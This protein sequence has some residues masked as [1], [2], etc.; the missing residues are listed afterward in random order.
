M[1]IAVL[2]LWHLGSVTA[3]CLAAAGHQVAGFDPAPAVV[4]GLQGGRPPIA[5]PGLSELVATGVADGT[6]RFTDDLASAVSHA[7]LVWVTFD[8]PVDEEDVADVRYVLDQVEAAF[9]HLATDAVVLCSSQLPVGSVKRL[10]EQWRTVA[11]ARRVSFASSPE[12]LR[13]GKAIDVFTH[14]D[15]VVVGVRDDRA[16]AVIARALAPIT[17]RIEWM[18]VESAEMTKHAVNAFL[19]TSVTFINELAS[20]CERVG[21]DAGDVERGLRTERRI[22]PQAYL[23]PGAAFAGGTLAR[24]VTFLRALGTAVG[25]PT[26]LMDGVLQSNTA[27]VS[28]A[29]RRLE[30][31]LGNLAGQRIAVW[32]LTYKP[33]TSTLRRSSAL[34]L[35]RWL[36]ERGAD[37]HVHDPQAEAVPDDVSVARHADPLDAAARAAAVVVETGWPAYREVSA[38]A[39]AAAAPGV[40][41][42][43]ANRFLGRTLGGDARFTVISVGQ[44]V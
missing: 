43:D 36:V 35:C 27:H 6:L 42:L 2:G 4:S 21:A 26:P 22:G 44:A 1:N 31:A 20:L 19:A 38:D 5:E 7:E 13:L 41:V 16:R 24:D 23:S 28:W 10:E 25:R 34:G 39:L 33:G 14:P 30:G 17:D 11:G 29:R 40:V 3:A 8:T 18:S 15:R 37:V 9:P 32:G 12:N